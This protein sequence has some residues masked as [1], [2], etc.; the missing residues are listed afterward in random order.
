MR[1]EG[2]GFEAVNLAREEG[3]TL[4]L[5]RGEAVGGAAVDELLGE[6]GGKEGENKD[7]MSEEEADEAGFEEEGE[8]LVLDDFFRGADFFGESL[9]HGGASAT[10]ADANQKS[11]RA[12]E[13]GGKSGFVEVEAGIGGFGDVAIENRL[14]QVLGDRSRLGGVPFCGGIVGRAEVDQAKRELVDG[15]GDGGGEGFGSGTESSKG[16]LE[17]ER[18]EESDDGENN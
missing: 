9:K 12:G 7:E 14:G 5:G 6:E 4:E 17:A 8:G 10:E 16:A 3:L 11:L 18:E 1:P 2:A 15:L 13:G